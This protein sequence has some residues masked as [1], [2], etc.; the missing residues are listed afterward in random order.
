[1]AAQRCLHST[2][3][4]R[5]IGR[6]LLIRRT[7]RIARI[8]RA[9]GEYDAAP[10][11]LSMSDAV[12][13]SA[14]HNILTI[15]IEEEIYSR[16]TVLRASY[17]FIERCYVFITRPAPGRLLVQLKCKPPSLEQPGAEPIETL[18]GEFTNALL[19]YQL[20]QDIDAQTGKIR[21]LLVAK[22]FAESG[23]LEDGPPGTVEDPVDAQTHLVKL[24]GHN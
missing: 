10:D 24:D 4:T 21:E 18:A 1:M 8:I 13:C 17:W 19:E 15:A 2:A 5:R 12:I 14:D 6:I 16:E 20:R 3:L 23:L 11:G 9:V 22:A 7:A